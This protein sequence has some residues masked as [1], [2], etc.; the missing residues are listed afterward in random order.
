MERNTHRAGLRV[1]N[2]R[3]S[4]NQDPIAGE[5][6]QRIA[7]HPRVRGSAG[8]HLRRK[9]H[10]VSLVGSA[11]TFA[12]NTLALLMVL[13]LLAVTL[14]VFVVDVAVVNPRCYRTIAAW[15]SAHGYALVKVHRQWVGREV[16][17]GAD[18]AIRNAHSRPGGRYFVVTGQ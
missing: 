6:R 7:R 10:P 4:T 13:L 16:I 12:V 11:D 9:G 15:A 5:P 2:W 18:G 1:W 14:G 3:R 17:R 8:R